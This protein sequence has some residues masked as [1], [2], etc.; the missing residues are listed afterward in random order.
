MIMISSVGRQCQRGQL[1]DNLASKFIFP[2]FLKIWS[3]CLLYTSLQFFGSII[4]HIQLLVKKCLVWTLTIAPS[5]SASMFS[6]PCFVAF[7]HH[8]GEI[9]SPS[10]VT[11]LDLRIAFNF[12][13]YN[14]FIFCTELIFRRKREC[15]WKRTAVEEMSVWLAVGLVSQQGV[16]RSRRF[17]RILH[18]L[19]DVRGWC[20]QRAAT[21]LYLALD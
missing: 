1:E 6:L 3:H 15:W 10:I 2:I 12:M 14:M 16:E 21:K 13:K 7:L 8:C 17:Q 4:S 18:Q 11:Q 5:K 19:R 20:Q 9:E